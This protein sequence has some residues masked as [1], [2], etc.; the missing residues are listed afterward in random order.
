[1][2]TPDNAKVKVS[3]L[4]RLGAVA[5]QIFCGILR[6]TDIRLVAIFGRMIGYLV[7]ALMPGRHRIV[8]RNL[9]IAVD[10]TL[11]GSK[12]SSLVRRN[13]VR[14]CMNMACTFKT[15]LMTDKEFQRAVR[16]EGRE[17]F[18]KMA[19]GG[20]CVIG[21][22]P[23]AGNWEVLARIRPLFPTVKR[24]GSMYRRLDNPLLEEIVLKSR[25]AYGCE[26]FSSQK[27]LK[28]VNVI[29]HL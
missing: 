1:M 18:E 16:V 10:P 25:T 13:I 12:L 7:W 26:M 4:Q 3:V 20:D 6:I 29:K 5:Y 15:G 11:C 9:R 21:C 8:A 22:I 23:H 28:E 2:S 24:F 27:G 17:E 19:D 14:T